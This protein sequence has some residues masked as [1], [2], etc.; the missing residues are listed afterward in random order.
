MPVWFFLFGSVC[1]FVSSCVSLYVFFFSLSMSPR[2]LV[3]LSVS[4]TT[5]RPPS[6][7]AMA[8]LPLILSL[9]LS[10]LPA[11]ANRL[12]YRS[13][14]KNTPLNAAMAC[15]G[16]GTMYRNLRGRGRTA[17][18]PPLPSVGQPEHVPYSLRAFPIRDPGVRV[19]AV[20]QQFDR[21]QI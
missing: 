9:L 12:S 3:C 11:A 18:V 15:M 21:F 5:C 17:E 2:V 1:L 16:G 7:Y 4:T 19:S 14:R 10:T 8:P 20:K 6:L 13:L